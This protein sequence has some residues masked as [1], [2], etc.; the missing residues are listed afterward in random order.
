MLNKNSDDGLE[1]WSIGIDKSQ[2]DDVLTV[3][4]IRNK[5]KDAE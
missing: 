1:L 2:Q 4:K 5:T 3:P